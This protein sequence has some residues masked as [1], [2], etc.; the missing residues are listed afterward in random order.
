AGRIVPGSRK[1]ILS[2]RIVII[3]HASSSWTMSA[4]QDLVKLPFQYLSLANPDAVPAGK[5]ARQYLSGFQVKGKTLWEILSPKVAPTLDVRAALAVVAADPSIVGIVYRTDA[6]VSNK[7]KILFEIPEKDVPPIVYTAARIQRPD[8]PYSAR[9]FYEFLF[10]KDA[11][12]IFQEHGFAP[13]EAKVA[14]R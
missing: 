7:V 3:A 9:M 14:A 2:N 11:Q 5:Y 13:L 6:V 10:T 8:A 12:R 4:P 1:A